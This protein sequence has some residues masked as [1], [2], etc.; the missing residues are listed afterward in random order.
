MK[1]VTVDYGSHKYKEVWEPDGVPFCP[2]CGQPDV[3]V[4]CS[5][6][7]YY[8]GPTFLCLMCGTSF[9]LPSYNPNSK[10]NTDI[11]RRAQLLS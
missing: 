11:Q 4:E 7:D 6:G 8:E 1:T 3:W 5:E 10:R 9:T 2:H